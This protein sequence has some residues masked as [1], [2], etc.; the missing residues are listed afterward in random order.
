MT[1]SP[2]RRA[3]KTAR[4][5]LSS[6]PARFWEKLFPK[7]VLALGYHMVSDE[8]LPHLKLCSYKNPRQFENDIAF[9]QGRTLEYAD[10]VNHR[11][12][13][14][15]LPPNQMLFTFDDGFAECFHVARPIL[16]KYAVSG[17]FFVTTD[18]IDDRMP[19]HE[20]KLSLCLAEIERSGADRV[21]AV[22]ETLARER[23]YGGDRNSH[24][25]SEL[26]ADARI[27]S[28][29]GKEHR[30]LLLALL[31]LWHDHE[32]ELDRLCELLG[33]DAVE[34]ARRRPVFM[35]SH[36]LKTLASEG[37]TVGGHALSHHMLQTLSRER[38]E[39]EI[40]LSCQIVRDIT[41]QKHVPFAFPYHGQ[42]ID[43][44]F[45]ADILARYPFIEMIFDSGPLRRGPPFVV[46]R[47]WPEEPTGD[48]S[49]KL[50]QAWSYPSAWFRSSARPIES[51]APASVV[52]LP[53]L[54]SYS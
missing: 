1:I 22:L 11:L 49:R 2:I 45:L 21:R 20:T 23:Q 5:V 37:F 41:G 50:S 3:K 8:D 13:G 38:M 4:A 19:F 16:K 15:A 42:G 47:V 29:L 10:V 39:E 36:Q 30:K 40:V 51:G 52:Y 54:D 43:R 6:V 31:S 26:L 9:A 48:L 25:T 46:D 53:T 24:R 14:A 27:S 35:S 44:S 28:H 33:V 32:P 12:R 17:V 18:F 34:Y 7:D